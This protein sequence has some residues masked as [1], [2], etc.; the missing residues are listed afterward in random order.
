M[1]LKVIA[2]FLVLEVVNGFTAGIGNVG[3]KYTKRFARFRKT[4]KKNFKEGSIQDWLF[5][6]F[7]KRKLELPAM[8]LETRL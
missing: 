1:I 5:F 8:R 7:S 2:I 4:E 6:I 3:C